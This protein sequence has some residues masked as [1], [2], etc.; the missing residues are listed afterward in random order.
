MQLIL[1]TAT[2]NV[3]PATIIVV[4][5]CF[6]DSNLFSTCK[7]RSDRVMCLYI[8]SV[9]QKFHCKHSHARHIRVCSR[10]WDCL[11]AISLVHTSSF[12]QTRVSVC[13][14]YKHA[15]H[16]NVSLHV[17]GDFVLFQS[18]RA[19][20]S[21]SHYAVM[22]RYLYCK[23]MRMYFRSTTCFFVRYCEM[24]FSSIIIVVVVAAAVVLK[25]GGSSSCQKIPTSATSKLSTVYGDCVPFLLVSL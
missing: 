21:L 3:S 23:A 7:T 18:V 5:I 20:V 12:R 22:F 8:S 19:C 10:L 14:Q 4:I 6:I 24:T 11:V 9:Q 15:L 17:C 16:V 2:A 25:S 13:V 1:D